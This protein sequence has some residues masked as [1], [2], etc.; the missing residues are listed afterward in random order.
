MSLEF[1]IIDIGLMSYYLGLEV[2]QMEEGIFIS[3]EAYIKDV[4]M[5]FK[6]TDCNHVNTPMKAGMKLSEFD[7]GEKINTTLFKSLGGSLRY[8]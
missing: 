8:N 1:E 3:R 2:K 7:D 4:L 5:K 6:M